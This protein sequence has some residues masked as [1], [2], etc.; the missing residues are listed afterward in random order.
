MKLVTH[1]CTKILLKS[2]AYNELHYHEQ[3]LS[4]LSTKLLIELKFLIFDIEF[5][6]LCRLFSV[7]RN[8][9]ETEQET[10]T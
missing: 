10:T 4:H 5:L 7:I 8:V 1:V 6:F 2:P 3:F 9:K